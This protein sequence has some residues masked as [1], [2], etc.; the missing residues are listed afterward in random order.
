MAQPRDAG[1]KFLPFAPPGE[2]ANVMQPMKEFTNALKGFTSGIAK[3]STSPITGVGAAVGGLAR[4]VGAAADVT[5]SRRAQANLDS[6]SM[7]GAAFEDS[8][9]MAGISGGM[10][11]MAKGLLGKLGKKDEGEAEERTADATEKMAD[12]LEDQGL[13]AEEDKREQ[14]SLLD[15]LLGRGKDTGGESGVE[16]AEGGPGFLSK[17]TGGIMRFFKGKFMTKLFGILGSVFTGL[18]SMAKAIPGLIQ[19][20]MPWIKSGGKFF[21]QVFKKLF[22]PVTMLLSVFEFAKGFIAGYEEGGI[23]EGIKM[24][25]ENLINS[26]FDVPLNM[27]KSV[28]AWALETFGFSEEAAAVDAFEFDI[29]GGFVKLFEAVGT[30]I[31]SVWDALVDSVLSIGTGIKDAAKGGIDSV[32]SFF[33][34]GEDDES[35]ESNTSESGMGGQEPLPEA[36]EKW[37]KINMKD[38][39]IFGISYN[40]D[41]SFNSTPIDAKGNEISTG[42]KQTPKQSQVKKGSSSP[43]SSTEPSTDGLPMDVQ[44]EA[45]SKWNKVE[46]INGVAYGISYG[47]DGTYTSTPIDAK[48][49]DI[50]VKLGGVKSQ[51]SPDL[52]SQ[53]ATQVQDSAMAGSGAGA[54]NVVVNNVNQTTNEGG[55]STLALPPPSMASDPSLAAP[56]Q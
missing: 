45:K 43:G 32:K 15:K 34:F 50:S 40:D 8:P 52:R 25:F 19:K 51:P 17:M 14:R 2:S 4:G 55:K 33:G 13:A 48:G 18:I 11:D 16:K 7:I 22:W 54:G 3:A 44:P 21:A 56:V 36:Y 29:S 20:M 41:G 28:V 12:A 24:G 27:L 6:E 37:D 53:A 38:G 35:V 26:L 46:V 1:G 5:K 10:A 49:N 42:G 23:I 39:A 47:P 30:M 31:T 9:L